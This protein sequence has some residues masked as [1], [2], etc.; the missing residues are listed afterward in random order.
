[1]RVW[2]E[3][4]RPPLPDHLKFPSLKLYDSFQLQ[5]LPVGNDRTFTM[6]IC[7]ITPYDATHIG[8]AATYVTFDLVHR[9]LL[10]AGVEVR[11]LEN[12]TDIDDPL[13]ERA[14]RDEVDW[15]QLSSSQVLLFE[16]DM[17]NLRVIPPQALVSVSESMERITRFIRDLVEAG[18]TY[19]IEDDLYL[20]ASKVTTFDDLPVS[21]NEAI[22]IFQE[23]G[24]DPQ[25]SGKR[26]PLDPLLWKPSAPDEPS[27]TAPWGA[28]RPGWHVECNAISH[29]LLEHA[30]EKDLGNTIS[31]QGGGADLL[32]PHHYM[33]SLQGRAKFGEPFA[34][35]F[36]HAGMIR[37]QGEKMSKSLGN[38][39][40]V[41]Q[42]I[43]EGVRPMAIRL[44]LINEA[45]RDERDWSDELL[46]ESNVLLDRLVALLSKELIPDPIHLMQGII[47]HLSNDLDT[48]SVLN[49]LH[50]FLD[51]A[52]INPREERSPGELSRFL[53]SVLGITI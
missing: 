26:H 3:V 5:T 51:D 28:G 15:R 33:T 18:K 29:L 50:K 53:D 41:S 10:A 39:V 8:H 43:N 21:M 45:Y 35:H 23:R 22:A 44:A 12:V 13:F 27:W 47:E 16:S 38:L 49:L 46:N 2:P 9:Y 20:D 24:G 30:G 25:R 1:M 37:Y 32:F 48:V 11:F 7:G 4:Y 34:Q 14:R 19:L 31:L 52:E 40:F 42:L 17:T 36:V 6:Y